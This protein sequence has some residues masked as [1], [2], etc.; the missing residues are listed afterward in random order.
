MN[1]VWG[2]RGYYYDKLS[3]IEQTFEDVTA[4]LKEKGILEKGDVYIGT[5][6]MPMHWA[7]RTNMMKLNIVK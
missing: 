6:H 3:D 1:L 4:I 7:G 2:I 5:A